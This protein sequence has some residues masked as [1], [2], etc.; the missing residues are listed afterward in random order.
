[1]ARGP[2]PFRRRR[3]LIAI[4]PLPSPRGWLPALAIGVAAG[5]LFYWADVTLYDALFHPV[6]SLRDLVYSVG[7]VTVEGVRMLPFVLVTTAI[8]LALNGLLRRRREAR[9]PQT[10]GAAAE[11]AEARA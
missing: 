7:E 5:F 6:R 10:E 11:P 9:M 2:I 4:G 8:A 1:M 3:G